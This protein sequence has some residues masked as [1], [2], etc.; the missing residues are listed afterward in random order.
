M[1]VLRTQRLKV[2]AR[3]LFRATV[4][5]AVTWNKTMPTSSRRQPPPSR[6]RRCSEPRR[7][8]PTAYVFHFKRTACTGIQ[9]KHARHCPPTPTLQAKALLEAN[10]LAPER[11]CFTAS[12]AVAGISVKLFAIH[13]PRSPSP[14][15]CIT[16]KKAHPGDINLA[17]KNI[18]TG[19]AVVGGCG[20]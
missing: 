5:V 15:Y 1:A 18:I 12:T 19:C 8:S 16:R 4:V 20:I 10:L 7:K 11:A 14:D 6:T 2:N 9:P 17:F 3:H 13:R